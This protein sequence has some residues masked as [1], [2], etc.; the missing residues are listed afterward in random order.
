ML[1][2]YYTKLDEPEPQTSK[3]TKKLER[4]KSLKHESI[5]YFHNHSGTYYRKGRVK[6]GE[7]L[8]KFESRVAE[9]LSDYKTHYSDWRN[10]DQAHQ[11][12]TPG[13]QH[14]FKNHKQN[15]Y[16]HYLSGYESTMDMPRA[17]VVKAFAVPLVI[18]LVCGFFLL[19]NKRKPKNNECAGREETEEIEWRGLQGGTEVL[20]SP[21]SWPCEDR[22]QSIQLKSLDEFYGVVSERRDGWLLAGNTD[23]NLHEY[24][25]K[26]ILKLETLNP[27]GDQFK[28]TIMA[29]FDRVEGER[30]E[31]AA[32]SFH[33][34]YP[35]IDYS[36]I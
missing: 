12:K 32:A 22:W 15:K 6:I 26:E 33:P 34:G 21:T 8:K 10:T 28:S 18:A 14:T 2:K 4:K 13:D 1:D 30:L 35:K 7:E 19:K 23:T 11:R 36:G 3:S 20:V 9:S 31:L 29:A 17:K 16:E 25:E 27:S 24:I 5:N